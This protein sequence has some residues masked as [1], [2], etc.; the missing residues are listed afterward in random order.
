MNRAVAKEILSDRLI[1]APNESASAPSNRES[2]IH[3]LVLTDDQAL[4]AKLGHDLE[5]LSFDPRWAS[6]YEQALDQLFGDWTPEIVVVDL[7][8]PRAERYSICRV[9]RTHFGVPV[10]AVGEEPDMPWPAKLG[11]DE[12]LGKPISP[13]SLSTCVRDVLQRQIA[14]QGAIVA[15]DLTLNPLARS[16]VAGHQSIDVNDDEFAL[17]GRLALSPDEIISRNELFRTIRGG[18]TDLD[19]WL[20]DIHLTRLM[21]KLAGISNCRISRAPHDQGFMLSTCAKF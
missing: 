4:S 20:V 1:Q 10:I 7:L 3:L 5:Q 18:A 8:I 14:Y 9:V 11:A 12:Y 19:R 15:G 17:L 21:V 6:T 2:V 13:L 16:V